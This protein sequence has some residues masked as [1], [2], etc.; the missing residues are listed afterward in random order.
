MMRSSRWVMALSLGA[1]SLCA[2]LIIA[3]A[4][5]AERQFV[6]LP[7]TLGDDT[8]AFNMLEVGDPQKSPAIRSSEAANEASEASPS[9]IKRIRCNLSGRYRT[10][11]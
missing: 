11:F 10:C 7:Q 6:P 4:H 5:A 2:C 3:G 9:Q 1:L 8:T